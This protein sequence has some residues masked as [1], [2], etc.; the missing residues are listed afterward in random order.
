V[1]ISSLL[2]AILLACVFGILKQ[3]RSIKKAEAALRKKTDELSA[4][5][6]QL[7]SL[8]KQLA[9]ADHVK[10]VYI[11]YVFTICSSY[12]NKLENFRLTVHKKLRVRQYDDAICITESTNLFTQEIKEFFQSFDAIFLGNFPRFIEDFNALLREEER[13]YPKGSE[14]LTPELR[15]FALMRLGINDS[16]KIAK[17][18]HY[19]PQTV[20]NYKLKVKNKALSSKEDF[21]TS[22]QKIG[23]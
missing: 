15:V 23:R 6:A 19:S 10:E 12:I 8:N 3:L 18:L 9:E 22:I 13:I 21:Y 14:F 16:G 11:G 5:N 2:A 4:V 20:Y 7:K 17:M 1:F